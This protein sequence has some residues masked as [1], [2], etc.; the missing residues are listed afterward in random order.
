MP[1]RIVTS[2]YRYQRPPRKRKAVPLEA[3]VIVVG[4]KSRRPDKATAAAEVLSRSPRH[5]DGAVQP[6]T[7]RKT[8][9]EPAVTAPPPGSDD[10]KSVIVT[11]KPK[12][13]RKVWADDGQETPP[14]IKDL[15]QRMM[16]GR[17]PGSST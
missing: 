6:S 7:L 15:I 5:H 12:S 8:E 9:R 16:L 11:T 10:R 2:T 17:R 1:A 14:E 4:K 13:L 3:P